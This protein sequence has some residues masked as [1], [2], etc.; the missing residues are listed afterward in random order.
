MREH[1][2]NLSPWNRVLIVFSL[3][4]CVSPAVVAQKITSDYDKATDFSSFKTYAW[5]EGTSVLDA[6][7][8]QEIRIS[9]DMDL[10]TKGLKKV[11]AKE[12]DLLIAYHGAANTDLNVSSFSDPTYTAMGGMPMMGTTVWSSGSTV[13]SVGRYIRKGTLAIVI[14]DRRQHKVIWQAAA[15]GTVKERQDERMAQLNKTLTKLLD[16]YPP[17]KK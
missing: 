7:V 15:K 8:D 3:I 12:A 1:P 11:E 14:Y 5:G 10:E 4:L 17:K 6:K 2:L 13:G 9:I 16:R